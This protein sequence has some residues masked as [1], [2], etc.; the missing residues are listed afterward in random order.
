[1]FIQSENKSEKV[2]IKEALIFEVVHHIIYS[3]I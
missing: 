3:Y 1:M 2:P